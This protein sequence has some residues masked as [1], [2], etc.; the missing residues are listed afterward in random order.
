MFVR[1][2]VVLVGCVPMCVSHPAMLVFVRMRCVVG[3][4]RCHSFHLPV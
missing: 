4:R 1:D 3:V 2:V